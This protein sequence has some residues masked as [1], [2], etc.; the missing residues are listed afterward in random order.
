MKMKTELFRKIV[1]THGR[2]S[3]LLATAYCL[4]R[5]GFKPAPYC[6]LL[7]LLATAPAFAQITSHNINTGNLTINTTGSYTITGTGEATANTITVQSGKTAYIT[8]NGVNIDVNNIDNAC[9]FAIEAGA[10]VYLTLEGNNTLK[11]GKDKAGLQAPEGAALVITAE[12]SGSL[13]ATSSYNDDYSG[14]GIGGGKGAAGG[15]ITISGGH[16]TANGSYYGGAGIGRSFYFFSF[17]FL[18]L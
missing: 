2:A 14:A 7:L 3:L 17:Y 11:S 15:H 16:I 18:L 12:S 13:T 9:A 10:T 4:V 5:A 6:L 8:L 1:Q